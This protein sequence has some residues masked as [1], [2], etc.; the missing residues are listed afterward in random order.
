MRHSI[1]IASHRIARELDNSRRAQKD[2]GRARV[3]R[4]GP[5]R[6]QARICI[7]PST[8][9]HHIPIPRYGGIFPPNFTKYQTIA[10][11]DANL[12][13]IAQGKHGLALLHDMP[14]WLKKT[15]LPLMEG[16]ARA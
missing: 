12:E 2:G 13:R 3:R 1:C 9:H 14:A 4:Y 10:E 8:P 7:H 6:A 11:T 5:P 15:L 16:G